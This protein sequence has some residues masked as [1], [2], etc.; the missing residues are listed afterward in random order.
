MVVFFRNI[1]SR[2]YPL[3]GDVLPNRTVWRIALAVL[4]ALALIS[5]T[6]GRL[7][8]DGGWSLNGLPVPGYILWVLFNFHL[9]V[10]VTWELLDPRDDETQNM[11]RGWRWALA[12]LAVVAAFV[13]LVAVRVA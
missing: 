6:G 5:G 11:K 10:G 3:K 7:E 9:C 12:S 13:S 8:S 4:C 1:R 2:L